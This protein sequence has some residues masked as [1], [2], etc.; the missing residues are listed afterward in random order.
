MI[1]APL[2]LIAMAGVLAAVLFVA[3]SSA[4]VAG[5]AARP[6]ALTVT[7]L[8]D[9]AQYEALNNRGEVRRLSELQ[10]RQ[11]V[12]NSYGDQVLD[13]NDAGVAVGS[14][15][16]DSGVP[17]RPGRVQA[18]VWDKDGVPTLLPYF[19]DGGGA[20]YAYAINDGG[21]IVGEA[22]GPLRPSP[23]N[24]RHLM[25]AYNVAVKWTR[26]P[27]G[28]YQIT[29]LV[30]HPEDF[31]ES[32][33][34][35]DINNAGQVVGMLWRDG[36][37]HAVT[38]DNQGN[39]TILPAPPGG[40]WDV[41]GINNR[42]EIIGTSGDFRAVVWTPTT[43][44]GYTVTVLPV[45]EG[46]T[47]SMIPGIGGGIND[48]GQIV[49]RLGTASGDRGILW[50]PAP[51]GGYTFTLLDPLPGYGEGEAYSINNRGQIAGRSTGGG[52]Q[53]PVLWDRKC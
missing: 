23:W 19:P 10:T 11:Y 5:Q 6:C 21:T 43:G 32:S 14:T 49:G 52:N 45:P 9:D 34:A 26:V 8:P 36:M 46:A 38:W 25:P 7:D 51:G 27:G 39:M 1:R 18:V 35:T 3:P 50:T 4:Q 12:P 13:M 2:R 16:I 22:A 15:S 29:P 44:G 30:N 40:V 42:G 53:T 20:A 41:V 33:K 31:S 24:P 47:F 37:W 28:G 17:G 48:K